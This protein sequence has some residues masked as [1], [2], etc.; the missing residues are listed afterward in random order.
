MNEAH[1]KKIS[2][3]M[4]ERWRTGLNRPRP[5]LPDVACGVQFYQ[6]GTRI[7][8]Q[9]RKD[10]GEK[11]CERC[12]GRRIQKGRYRTKRFYKHKVNKDVILDITL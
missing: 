9:N 2:E 6:N 11:K 5:L 4:K 12:K 3:M 10:R 8:C 7:R 1:R